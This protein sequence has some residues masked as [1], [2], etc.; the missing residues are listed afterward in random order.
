VFKR[1]EGF[2]VGAILANVITTELVI[3]A[4]YLL[5]LPFFSNYDQLILRFFLWS[6]SFSR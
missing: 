3:L 4:V 5:S 2:F 1:E 6:R